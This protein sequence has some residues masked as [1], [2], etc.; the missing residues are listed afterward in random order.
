MNVINIDC[1]SVK[2]GSKIIHVN[3]RSI[4]SKLDELK[5]NLK[6]FDIIV[7]T[8]TWLNSSVTDSMLKWENFQ[9]VRL[10]RESFRNKRGGGI[11]LYIR[12]AIHFQIVKDFQELLDNNVKFMY[13]KLK[14][15]IC[16]NP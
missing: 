11:C 14:P 3:T 6:D 2:K 10:D 7:F 1:I 16:K 5:Y 9:L 8:E 12:S 15:Y 4:F 13:L